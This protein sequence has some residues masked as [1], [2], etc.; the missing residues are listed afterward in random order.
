MSVIGHIISSPGQGQATELICNKIDMIGKCLDFPFSLR[1]KSHE[2]EELRKW[3]HLRMRMKIFPAIVR[4]RSEL[5]N[6]IH[7]Y[8]KQNDFVHVTTPLITSNDCEGGGEVFTVK[9]NQ[10]IN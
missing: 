8:M 1:G 9:V 7:I 2:S 5:M 10:Q 6:A 3:P 4:L